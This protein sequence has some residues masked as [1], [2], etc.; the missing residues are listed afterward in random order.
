M[1]TVFC[2]PNNRHIKLLHKWEYFQF[3]NLVNF[4]YMIAETFPQKE[5]PSALKTFVS[6]DI[7]VSINMVL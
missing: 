5:Q 2:F 6:F 3:R 7:I 4:Y 1:S